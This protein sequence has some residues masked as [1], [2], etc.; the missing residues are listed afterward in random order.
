MM[1]SQSPITP[2]TLILPQPFAWADIP[3][4][5]VTLVRPG[6]YLLQPVSQTLAPFALAR[7]PITNAQYQVFVDAPDGYANDSW[8]AYSTAAGEWRLENPLPSP[9][10]FGG[11]DH[12]RTHVTWYEAVAF[13]RWLSVRTGDVIRLPTEAEWQWAAQGDDGR[14]YPW[15][16]EWDGER[17][18]N[19]TAVKQIGTAPVISYAGKGDSPFGV[20][21]MVG[22]VWEWC[23]TSWET[24]LDDLRADDVRVLRGGSWFDDV[25]ACFRTTYRASWNPE[26]TS[27]LR[28]FRILREIQGSTLA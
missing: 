25:M 3:G 23:A 20:V 10:T 7:Y 21:D 26:I 16:I 24:G 14:E 1:F 8:W 9:M 2:T 19:N 5:T 13:C 4:G 11:S 22:N 17:C 6:G 18:H 15:G 12:P 27:D 28:G